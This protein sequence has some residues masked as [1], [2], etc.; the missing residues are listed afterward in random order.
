ML[1]HTLARAQVAQAT[2]MLTTPLD[3]RPADALL[4]LGRTPTPP[5][6]RRRGGKG[7]RRPPT[8]RRLHLKP[9]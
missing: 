7:H 9:H 6:P 1:Q 4:R 5:G 2:G 8:D 3:I